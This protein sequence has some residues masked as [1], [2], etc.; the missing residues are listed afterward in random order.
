MEITKYIQSNKIK[1]S[2]S[3]ILLCKHALEIMR[4]SKDPLHDH[5]HVLRMTLF[6][7]RILEKKEELKNKIDLEIM[8]LSIFWH[9]T[10]KAKKYST[11]PLKLL[12]NDF[13]EGLGSAFLFKKEALKAKIDQEVISR[14]EYC[15]RKHSNYQLLPTL[16][17]EAKMLK[18]LDEIELWNQKRI[19][20][21]QRKVYIE[22][23][24]IYKFLRKTFY[25]LRF[26][27]KLYFPPLEKDFYK[28]KLNLLENI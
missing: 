9:D 23:F 16:T 26:Y 4:K 20:N 19:L 11:N 3:T 24:M 21:P 27:R 5:N 2:K 8:M 22:T 12:I 25:N 6:L 13:Y 10:W 17:H 14:V 1:I 28:I 7:S 18:D 15:I